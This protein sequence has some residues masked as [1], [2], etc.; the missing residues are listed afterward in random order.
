MRSF[1]RKMYSRIIAALFVFLILAKNNEAYSGAVKIHLI[2]YTISLEASDGYA[3]EDAARNL[4]RIYK[5]RYPNEIV[6]SKKV[7][8]G[9]EII[10]TIGG[11][12]DGS[13]ASLDIVSHGNQFG[14]HIAHGNGPKTDPGYKEYADGLYLTPIKAVLVATYYKQTIDFSRARYITNL[15]YAK[16][17]GDAFVEFHGCKIADVNTIS[18]ADNFAQVFSSKLPNASLVIAHSTSANPNLPSGPRNISDY[19]HGIVSVY[20]NGRLLTSAERSNLKFNHS[21]TPL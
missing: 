14:V 5:S 20:K 13:I 4:E 10:T 8:G 16:F 1:T 12:P 3:F 11:V 6:I 9:A 2:I 15:N 19:R 21:S 7:N 18:F 17:M